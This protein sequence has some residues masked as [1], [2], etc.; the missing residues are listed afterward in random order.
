MQR[1][2]FRV[3]FCVRLRPCHFTLRACVLNISNDNNVYHADLYSGCQF[4][5]YKPKQTANES[6]IDWS[7]EITDVCPSG[8]VMYISE[9]R[10][11]CP[12]KP[13][14]VLVSTH[15]WSAEPLKVVLKVKMISTACII[16]YIFEWISHLNVQ[17]N[18]RLKTRSKTV[19]YRRLVVKQWNSTDWQPV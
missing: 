16:T 9:N 6:E 10:L 4:A 14:S 3:L 11:S 2:Y 19:S 12:R 7:R 5:H 8:R 13:K 18:E 1:W 17:L 15:C